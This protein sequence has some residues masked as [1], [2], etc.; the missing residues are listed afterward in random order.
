[1]TTKVRRRTTAIRVATPMTRLVTGGRGTSGRTGVRAFG[2]VGLR[3]V[4]LDDL[5]SGHAAFVPE[6]VTLVVG[7]VA[8]TV[9]VEQTLAEHQITGVVRTWRGSSTQACR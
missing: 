8:D 1:M 4:V 9:L 3:A 2:Q 6:G 7:R 5:S